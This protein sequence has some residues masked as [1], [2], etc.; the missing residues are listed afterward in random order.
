[1][2]QVIK[3]LSNPFFHLG[4]KGTIAIHK[5]QAFCKSQC[6]ELLICFLWLHFI[7][8]RRSNLHSPNKHQNTLVLD[9]WNH[10]FHINLVFHFQPSHNLLS[11]DSGYFKLSN[12]LPINSMVICKPREDFISLLNLSYSQKSEL[13]SNLH[14]WASR[15]K[16]FET[17]SS[18]NIFANQPPNL[19]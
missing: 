2:I 19:H 10:H 13:A 15:S 14:S 12:L 1:M 8:K 4:E 5:K 18:C 3:A 9:P 16:N 6:I 7:L 17:H 11:Q